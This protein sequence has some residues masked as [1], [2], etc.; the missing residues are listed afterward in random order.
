MSTLITCDKCHK[1]YEVLDHHKC[2][3][4][5]KG[6][7][8][9]ESLQAKNKRLEGEVSRL[10]SEAL[11][12]I[13][14]HMKIELHQNAQSG[15]SLKLVRERAE[16]AEVKLADCEKQLMLSRS[17]RDRHIKRAREA[18]SKVEKLNRKLFDEGLKN[19]A[20]V[21]RAEKAE[22]KLDITRESISQVISDLT[23][24]PMTK[25]AEDTVKYLEWVLQETK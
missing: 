16:K 9:I 5:H 13:E 12:L 3:K 1:T 23:D 7:G 4:S 20:D 21:A 10:N 11:T 17:Q 6:V 22:A 15:E 24:D 8:V 19:N 25:W 2:I 14:G 18:E